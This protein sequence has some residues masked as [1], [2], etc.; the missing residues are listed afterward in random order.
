LLTQEKSGN[1]K[2][3]NKETLK[4]AP[5]CGWCGRERRQH[6]VCPAKDATCNK[7]KKGDTFKMFV[8]ALPSNPPAPQQRKCMSWKM[9]KSRKRE[10]RFN[11]LEK[12]KPQGVDRPPNSE[13]M[14]TVLASS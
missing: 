5:S 12:F 9:M 10:M 6:Q 3:P 8:T 7:C 4:P 13:L 14:A 1:K 2:L 11:F